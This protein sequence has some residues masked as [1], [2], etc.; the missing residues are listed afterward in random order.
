MS[1]M[2]QKRG[3]GLAASHH[4]RR[5]FA[6]ANS[7]TV[8]PDTPGVADIIPLNR[9]PDS[10]RDIGYQTPAPPLHVPYGWRLVRVDQGWL[11]T[12]GED[13][14]Q[15]ERIVSMRRGGAK[16]ETIADTLQAEGVPAPTGGRSLP[17]WNAERV[18]KLVHHYAP[19]I[20]NVYTTPGVGPAGP[21]PD[22]PELDDEFDRLNERARDL[23]LVDDDEE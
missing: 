17:R 8:P 3:E 15:I 11:L 4:V 9:T 14:G 19:A 7:S 10:T 12:H 23:G 16:Y 1:P 22:S 13:W 5:R 20:A 6:V 18:R 21:L 2:P